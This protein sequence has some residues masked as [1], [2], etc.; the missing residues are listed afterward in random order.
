MEKI[1][2]WI[3][4]PLYFSAKFIGELMGKD[5]HFISFHLFIHSL[6]YVIWF[7]MIPGKLKGYTVKIIKYNVY[8]ISYNLFKSDGSKIPYWG[9]LNSVTKSKIVKRQRFH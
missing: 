4:F 2:A 6:E 9:E 8:T 1:A 5:N 3:V 7:Y